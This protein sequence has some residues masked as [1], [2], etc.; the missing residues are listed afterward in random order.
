MIHLFRQQGLSISS[1]AEKTGLDRKTVRK[2]LCRGLDAPRYGPRSPMPS[3]VDP[4]VDYLRQRLTEFPS[5][6]AARLLREVQD[7]GYRGSYTILRERVRDLRPPELHGY[8]HRFE[9]PPGQQAQVDF[10]YF[11]LA[12]TEA[13]WRSVV[14]W[15]FTMVLGFSRYLVGRFVLRQNLETFLRCHLEA[16]SQ[17][18]G[19]PR[20]ILYDRLRAAVIGSDTDGRAIFHPVLLD[21]ARHFGFIPRACQPYRAKTKGKVERPYRYIRQDFF[22]GREFRDL[23]DLNGQF[24]DWLTHV[25]NLRCH[26]TTRRVVVEA[27]EEER[28][29][30]L[31]L[32]EVPYSNV[33]RLERRVSRD[34]LVSVD[35]NAYS[36]PDTTRNRVVEVHSLLD[37]IR[38]FDAG[39]LVAVHE[40]LR[41]RGQSRIADGHR[42]FPPPGNAKVRREETASAALTI[43][44]D[45]VPIRPLEVYDS[46]ASALA[47]A[48][49]SPR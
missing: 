40:P 8:E 9:T 48:E 11:R 22:L 27:L 18:G 15:L 34:G 36:V 42:R 17:I 37:E 31:A 39:R 38:I 32:P 5:L 16:F 24:G 26:G 23:E 35:G 12:F 29:C 33:L 46:I 28:S 6:S 4:Y 49:R 7:L 30:L 14:V 41:G 3:L 45:Q 25:A 44:G 43:P 10:A 1:I 13:P 21:L 20:E 47:S 19:V 2:R